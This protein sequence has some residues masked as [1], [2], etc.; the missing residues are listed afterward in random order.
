MCVPSSTWSWVRNA[1]MLVGVDFDNTIVC[2]DQAFH[3]AALERGLIPAD[4]PARK[5]SVRDYLRGQGQEDAWI[6]LQGWVYGEG[7]R[8]ALPFPGVMDFFTCCKVRD[9]PVHIISHRTRYPFQGPR[10]DLHRAAQS[11]LERHGLKD[12]SG[13]GASV[14]Q[15]HFELTKQE[16]LTR[17]VE[18]GCSHFIDDLPEFLGEPGFPPD[19]AAI[20]FD[21]DGQIAVP[22]RIRPATSWSQIGEFIFGEN[23]P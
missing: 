19:V 4:V 21:P 15:I 11:W 10:Y 12:H 9:I 20:L 7:M 14:R 8:D 17:I 16:K 22:A 1:A 18:A 13:L 5:S 23:H 2:Y 6:K 3:R